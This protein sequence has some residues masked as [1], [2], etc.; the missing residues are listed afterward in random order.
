MIR[1]RYLILR[2]S[3][4]RCGAAGPCTDPIKSLLCAGAT[5][6]LVEWGERRIEANVTKIPVGGVFVVSNYWVRKKE[7]RMEEFI[8]GAEQRGCELL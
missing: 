6:K 1:V 4:G 8:K 7:D 5:D 3:A 2:G